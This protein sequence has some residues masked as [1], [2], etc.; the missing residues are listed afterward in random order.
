MKVDVLPALTGLDEASWNGL[1]DRSAAP[2]VFLTW[3][4]QTEWARAF[5]PDHPLQVLAVTDDD[6][7]PFGPQWDDDEQD[8]GDQRSG[9]GRERAEHEDEGGDL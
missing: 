7:E 4:W 9:I 5:A 1:L 3:T 6:G 8:D 2:S